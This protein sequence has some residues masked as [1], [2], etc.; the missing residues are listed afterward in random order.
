MITMIE[1]H[2][3]SDR[4]KASNSYLVYSQNVGES[5]I[6]EYSSKKKYWTIGCGMNCDRVAIDF[7]AFIPEPKM[8]SGE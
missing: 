4:P 8:E 1:W 2:E 7:W 6:A 5:F 3:E